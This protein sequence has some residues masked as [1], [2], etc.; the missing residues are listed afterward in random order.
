MAA[1]RGSIGFLIEFVTPD[2]FRGPPC[3]EE[4]GS[5]PFAC[6]TVDPGISPG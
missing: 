1:V 5:T 2:W 4:K 3:G 6:G